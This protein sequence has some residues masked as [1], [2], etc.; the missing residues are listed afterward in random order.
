M[1]E[2]IIIYI[3]PTSLYCTSGVHKKYRPIV[4]IYLT[5]NIVI[6]DARVL[7]A[8]AYKDLQKDLWPFYQYD[9]CV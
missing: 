1:K 2:D 6:V 8:Y 3:V 7:Q 9:V 4:M 5:S